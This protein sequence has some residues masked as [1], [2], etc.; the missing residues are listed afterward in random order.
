ML[1]AVVADGPKA[2]SS[3]EGME[4]TRRTSPYYEPFLASIPNDLE[5]ARSAVLAR[6]LEALGVV[7]ERNCLRMHAAMLAS[8]PALLYLRPGSLEALDCVR[9]LRAAGV[10]A[11]FTIDAGP[12]VKVLCERANATAV[13]GALRAVPGVSRVIRA[14]PGPGSRLVEPRA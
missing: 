12:N 2:V 13:E 11:F 3:T 6:D 5:A 1:V 9:E 7:M 14:T 8:E 10:P 4:R